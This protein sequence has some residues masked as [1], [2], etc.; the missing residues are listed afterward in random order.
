MSKKKFSTFNFQFSIIIPIFD[1]RKKIID[2][3]TKRFFENIRW[4]RSRFGGR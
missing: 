1:A 2:H 4:R 3:G